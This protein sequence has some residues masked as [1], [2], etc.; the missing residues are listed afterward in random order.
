[1]KVKV[2]KSGN[3]GKRINLPKAIWEK[4]KLSI[5]DEVELTIQKNGKV[6]LTKELNK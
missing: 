1:M 6:V 3:N 4:L 2:F 5:G